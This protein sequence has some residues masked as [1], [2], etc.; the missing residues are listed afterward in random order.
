M[1]F[2]AHSGTARSSRKT[3]TI[4]YSSTEDGS[5]D[6]PG[7]QRE[8]AQY[9]ADMILELR[10]LARSAKLYQVM[11]PLEYSYYEAFAVANKVQVSQEEVDHLNE[12]ARASHEFEAV[13]EEY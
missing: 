8:T 5:L 11:V 2:N 7:R 10:N 9:L 6:E 3:R 12:L 4:G 13:P 1:N